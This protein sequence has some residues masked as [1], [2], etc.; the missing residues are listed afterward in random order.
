MEI[1]YSD[2]A[3]IDIKYWKKSGNF[4]VQK[5][6]STLLESIKKTPYSGIGKPEALK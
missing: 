5:K 6:I 4:Q 1:V 2:Q 3:L